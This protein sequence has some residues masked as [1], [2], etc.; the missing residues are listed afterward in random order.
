MPDAIG[1]D[2]KQVDKNRKTVNFFQN[3]THCSMP[4][5][6]TLPEDTLPIKKGELL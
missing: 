6:L 1:S 5:A 4:Q 3:N 2:L